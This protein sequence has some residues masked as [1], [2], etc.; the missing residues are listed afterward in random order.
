[1]GAQ[2]IEA[3]LAPDRNRRKCDGIDLKLGFKCD[4]VFV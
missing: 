1:M 2:E 4:F 3:F